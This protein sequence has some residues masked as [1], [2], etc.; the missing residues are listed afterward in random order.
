MSKVESNARNN[1]LDCDDSED[2]LKS[3]RQVNEDDTLS[4]VL[5]SE[6]VTRVLEGEDDSGFS[7]SPIDSMV[8]FSEEVT[9][10]AASH[11]GATMA[12]CISDGI[13]ANDIGSLLEQ[14]LEYEKAISPAMSP[15][16]TAFPTPMHSPGEETKLN[17][18]ADF[19][20]KDPVKRLQI[21]AQTETP[22]LSPMEK[23]L[24]L[25]EEEEEIL[26]CDLVVYSH[27]TIST[28]NT[29]GDVAGIKVD[30]EFKETAENMET[31]DVESIKDKECVVVNRDG[32]VV[33]EYHDAKPK[34]KTSNTEVQ[35]NDSE[36]KENFPQRK[37]KSVIE[38]CYRIPKIP[39]DSKIRSRSRSP[40]RRHIS[41]SRD[42]SRSRGYSSSSDEEYDRRDRFEKYKSERRTPMRKEDRRKRRKYSSCSDDEYDYY[43]YSKRDS[44]RSHSPGRARNEHDYNK[45]R[46]SHKDYYRSTSLRERSERGS[47]SGRRHRKVD[48][49]ND[50][51]EDV[52][53]RL[54]TLAAPV[55]YDIEQERK[56]GFLV[57]ERRSS[58]HERRNV[59]AGGIKENMTRSDLIRRFEV[60]GPIERV[61][62]HFRE[63]GDN[64]AFIVFE[65]SKDAVR[66][67]EEG[68]NDPNY[69]SLDLCFGG[70]RKFV[71][72]SYV[73]FD[74][75]ISY[76]E[77]N[78]LSC[79]RPAAPASDLEFDA[80]LKMAKRQQSVK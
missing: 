80:L 37:L 61:T 39:R 30:D 21:S 38:Q 59:Y 62:L 55:P 65:D 29:D 12:E 40:L 60:F 34:D 63:E 78:D 32:V 2:I 33:V 54:A 13:E 66:A 35:D 50:E 77:E 58:G 28:T 18:D 20:I 49:R 46:R 47:S 75:N 14:F 4:R 70:R 7:G 53:E 10:C 52:H 31:V 42:R 27:I 25:C 22:P 45:P 15:A 79:T 72:G 6:P 51:A 44:G 74:A 9:L 36:T 43:R 68:N 24:N 69:T 16:M 64:Y 56:I 23:P 11:V 48:V 41:R 3:L 5:C 67:V 76:L 57:H 73:D 19:K 26:G 1:S 17:F 71:G 8:K